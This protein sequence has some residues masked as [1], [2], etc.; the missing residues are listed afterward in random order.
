MQPKINKLILKK[1]QKLGLE[2]T[3]KVGLVYSEEH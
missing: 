1:N 2:F 3:F